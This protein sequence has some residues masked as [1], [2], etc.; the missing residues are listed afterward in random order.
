MTIILYDQHNTLHVSRVPPEVVVDLARM[1]TETSVR[2][3]IRPDEGTIPQAQDP[4]W[5]GLATAIAYD[6]WGD[7]EYAEYRA[8]RRPDPRD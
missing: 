8:G 7:K 3:S 1:L 2:L 5:F 6:T 4:G